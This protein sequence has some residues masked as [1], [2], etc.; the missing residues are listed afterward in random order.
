MENGKVNAVVAIDVSAAFD[1]VDHSIMLQV[2]ENM[3]NVE[4]TAL[5]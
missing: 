4:N 1:T 3:N 5:K 2:L